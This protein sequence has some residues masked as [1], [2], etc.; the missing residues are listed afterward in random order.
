VDIT[1]TPA[2]SAALDSAAAISQTTLK[3]LFDGDS[4]RTETLSVEVLV[5][6]DAL[7][8]DFSKQNIDKNS[9]QKLIAV[10]EQAGV[11]RKRNDMFAGVIVNGTENQPA[12]HT[13]LRGPLGTSIKVDG[14]DVMKEIHRVRTLVNEFAESV[15]S[16]SVTGAT[17][18]K[19]QSV[20]NVGIGGSDLGPTLVHEALSSSITPAVR[21]HFVSNIDPTDVRAVLQNCDPETTFVVLCSKS[22]STAETLS[23]GRII[24]QWISDAV[25]A[26]NV[27]KHFAVVSVFPEKAASAGLAADYA[28]P[29][30][31]WVGGRY[32]ISSAVNLV[33]VIA[34]GSDA[35]DN[36]LAG[37]RAMDDHFLSA[38][39]HRNAP[40][41]MGLLNIWN[42][43][44][45]GR[46]TRAM[47]AYSTALKSFASYVQ[48]LEMES[49]GKRVTVDGQPVAIPTSPIV[50]G[51]VGT[52]AQHA[53]M[54]LLHQGTSVVPADFIGV[55][56]TPTRDTEA[57][58]ALVANLIAQT[59]A[60]AFGNSAEPHRTLPGNRPSTTL[61]LSS[62]TP[63]T[64][65][66]LIALYEHSVF[67]QGC[68]FGINS[69]D[70][71]GVELGKKLATEV[72]A[73]LSATSQA[74]DTDASTAQ[75]VQWYKKHRSNT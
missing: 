2:W 17:G 43:S 49:N 74:G 23:N 64:L 10:A 41:L 15:R 40:V 20:I 63:H 14:V 30:W 47:I 75:L 29:M 58:D 52:N 54:Q 72:S 8:V 28:F 35:F 53:Y 57:H 5:G 38:P 61:M 1:T 6:K 46:E 37:M 18:K 4:S 69:F 27:S 7:L 42:R 44:L 45:L 59:Q 67:V 73:Q 36:M 12:L 68:V 60:L 50:W 22:F 65:G 11:E 32:S 48:Q 51:G 70:Q 25:G 26:K 33:N 3:D 56:A 34:F 16:G 39:L 19:F 31:S 62:L 55:A 24:A 9:L 13:A 71:W 66:S 21:T